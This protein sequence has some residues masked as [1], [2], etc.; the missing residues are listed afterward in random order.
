MPWRQ[1]EFLC[2]SSPSV[3]ECGN[4][5]APAD[6]D[7]QLSKLALPNGRGDVMQMQITQAKTADQIEQARAL[8]REYESWLGL[9]LCFQ[10]FENELA[11][12]PGAYAEP[13]GRLF[14]A[15]YH[16]ELAGC[17][18][19]RK[20]SDRNCE[21]KRLF[22]RD[23]F[24]GKGLGR[25]LIETIIRKAKEIGYERMLL[26][27]LPPRMNDAIALYQSIGFKEIAS[28]Y[29]NPVEGAIFMELRLR[30]S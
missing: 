25:L 14:L 30:Q 3:S 24:R 2:V 29:D 27:T 18:A 8:F 5:S 19:L 4:P 6:C 20:L 12:L 1:A 15:C 23:K 17:V 22:V 11:E 9:S 16:D 7:E 21:M 10:N 13:A 28:Y 26:D